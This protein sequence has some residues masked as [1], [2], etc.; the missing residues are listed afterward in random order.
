[1]TNTEMIREKI[2][3][4]GL[5]LNYIC[6]QLGLSW[7]GLANKIENR[8]EF[9]QSEIVTL[10]QILRLTDEER[11]Q[12]FFSLGVEKNSTEGAENA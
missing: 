9:R 2:E 3:K 12:I 11:E 1:M 8:T 6:E 10:S 5:K 4:S 7:G